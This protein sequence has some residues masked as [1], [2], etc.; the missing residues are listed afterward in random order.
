MEG[1]DQRLFVKIGKDTIV[2]EPCVGECAGCQKQFRPTPYEGK[3]YCEVYPWPAT[4]WAGKTCPF[5]YKPK[6]E[7]EAK[8]NPLKA[9]KRR[10]RQVAT[11]K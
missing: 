9:S 10:N 1:I 11:A 4:K 3:I 5:M 7:R 8:I 2:R 6:A